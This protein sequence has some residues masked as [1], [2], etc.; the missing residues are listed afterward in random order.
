MGKSSDQ[1]TESTQNQNTTMTPTN[2]GFVTEGLGNLG[3][4]LDRL[5]GSDPYSFIAP[6]NPLQEQAGQG[7]AGLTGTPGTYAGANDLATSVGQ[8]DSPD[9]ASLMAHFKGAFDRRVINPALAGF[10][11][12]SNLVNAQNHLN[13]GR[14]TTFGGSGAA[15]TDALTRGQQGLARGQLEGGLLS[16]QFKTALG[17]ATSQAGVNQQQQQLRLNAAGQLVSSANDQ[18]ATS[19]ANVTTQATIGDLLRQIQQQRTS[20]PLSVAGSLSQDYGALPLGLLHGVNTNG[21]TVGNSSTHG[22]EFGMDG[23]D[24][25]KLAMA[26]AMF[27]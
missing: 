17:G 16:D 14:D 19:R 21:T 3:G 6:T 27:A 8:M 1:H 12:N 24:L 22:T 23:A 15:I 9:I 13:L 7:A 4:T 25:A 20:A 10:D 26:A 2:P 5:N 18:G 11:Q